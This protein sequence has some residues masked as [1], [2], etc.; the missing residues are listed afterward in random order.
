[1]RNELSYVGTLRNAKRFNIN[2]D[3]FYALGQEII[4]GRIVGVELP[5]TQN[6]EYIYKVDLPEESKTTT[7]FNIWKNKIGTKDLSKVSAEDALKLSPE[8]QREWRKINLG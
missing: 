7:E 4:K 2:D 3:I 5:P 1:M 6:P 8:K